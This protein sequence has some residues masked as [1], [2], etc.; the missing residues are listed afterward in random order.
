MEKIVR[1]P[2]KVLIDTLTSLYNKGVDF[3]DIE[4]KNDDNGEP[5]IFISFTNDYINTDYSDD[6]YEQ[7]ELPPPSDDS[8]NIDDLA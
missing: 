8:L 4:K 7:E 6:E 2:V 3:F 1:L 5:S